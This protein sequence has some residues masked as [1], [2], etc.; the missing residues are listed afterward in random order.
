MDLS[1]NQDSSFLYNCNQILGLPARILGGAKQTYSAK[2]W[3]RQGS[4]NLPPPRAVYLFWFNHQPFNTS[5]GFPKHE[6]SQYIHARMV[7]IYP[8]ELP[9]WGKLTSQIPLQEDTK[10]LDFLKDTQLLRCTEP[11]L[12][13]IQHQSYFRYSETSNSAATESTWTRPLDLECLND[14]SK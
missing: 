12:S 8:H 9:S 13:A 6:I 1:T 11:I 2:L 5:N 4:W 14:T 3:S 7:S 10:D